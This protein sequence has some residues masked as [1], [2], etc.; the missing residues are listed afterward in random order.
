MANEVAPAQRFVRGILPENPIFRQL[1]GLCPALA[2]SASM[3]SAMTM[4]IC[5]IF[6]LLCSNILTSLIRNM[7]K[8][9]LRILLFT[10]IIATFVTVVDKVL[11]AYFWEMSKALGPYVPLIIVNCIVLCRCEVCASKQ[12]LGPAVADALGQGL[13]FAVAL[14][15]IAGVRE[16]L[17]NGTWFDLPLLP[18]SIWPRWII[19]MLA[20]GAFIVLGLLVGLVNWAGPA[21]ARRRSAKIDIQAVTPQDPQLQEARS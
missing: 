14:A 17:G 21:L 12:T 11:G 6:V 7:V 19:M 15:A 3:K 4:A 10:G 16:I 2:V 8:P 13:G 18:E 1:L 9:H 20:P 5:V